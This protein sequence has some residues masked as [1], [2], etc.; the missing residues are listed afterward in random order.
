MK[1]IFL[2]LAILFSSLLIINNL[3]AQSIEQSCQ[4]IETEVKGGI[5]KNFAVNSNG[6]LTY[7]YVDDK[8]SETELTIDLTKVSVIKD[9]SQQGYKVFIRCLDGVSCINE[10]GRLVEDE[11]FYADFSKTYIPANDE[12]GMNIVYQHLLFLLKFGNT[13]R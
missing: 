11:N 10:K 4:I 8:G 3:K 1:K 12:K 13:N 7:N 6:Y 9:V 5:Y 2:G